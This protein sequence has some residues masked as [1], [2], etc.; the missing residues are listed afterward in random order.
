MKT[1]PYCAERIK[2]QAVVCRF[3][4]RELPSTGENLA[5]SEPDPMAPSRQAQRSRPLQVWLILVTIFV[6]LTSLCSLLTIN[7][8]LINQR[9]DAEQ[10]FYAGD[11]PYSIH[12]YQLDR[13]INIYST[14]VFLS[15]LVIILF[16]VWYF[17]RKIK[18]VLSSV[19]SIVLLA[20]D[21]LFIG[22]ILILSMANIDH[23]LR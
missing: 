4:G 5:H 18:N 17:W 16:G 1:C 7:W 22:W 14:L 11:M 8:M 3:C 19:L 12:S 21:I 15:V 9:A 20:V 2:D 10:G 6:I 23:L 13:E